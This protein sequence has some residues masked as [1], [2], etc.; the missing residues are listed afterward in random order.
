MIEYLN[1]FLFR[2]Q[3]EQRRAVIDKGGG[4]T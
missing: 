4:L 3:K 2:R 1:V